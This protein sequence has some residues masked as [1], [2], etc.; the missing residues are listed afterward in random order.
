LR[1]N[2]DRAAGL[3]VAN[4]P[5][6]PR[7][8]TLAKRTKAVNLQAG[9]SPLMDA[10]EFVWV[11]GCVS[12]VFFSYL[13][14]SGIMINAVLIVL[15]ALPL[16]KRF[17]YE[18]FGAL[19]TPFDIPVVLV[20]G[21]AIVGVLFSSTRD[22]SAGA[23]QSLLALMM[24]YYYF[25]THPNPRRIALWVTLLFGILLLGVTIV[26]FAAEPSYVA[27]LFHM[28]PALA[29]LL[30]RVP[31]VPTPGSMVS[32]FT[33]NHG[34]ATSLLIAASLAVCYAL[35]GRHRGMRILSGMCAVAFLA[36][37]AG[38]THAALSRL[39]ELISIDTRM[40]LWTKT[41][42]MLKAHP[43][44]GL[45]L[46]S[47]A[48][49]YYGG[50]V[51]PDAVGHPHSAYLEIY[52]DFGLLGV[53]GFFAIAVVTARMAWRMLRSSRLNPWFGYSV[54]LIVA[55]VLVA[56]VG[57]LESAPI[58]IPLVGYDQYRYVLSPVPWLL[59]GFLAMAYKITALP[60][61]EG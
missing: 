30:E 48:P 52:A 25:A 40:E 5:A 9:T 15:C 32:F 31:T 2:E 13:L 37:L 51:P 29:G 61:R 59:L 11:F 60:R 17:A 16:V 56:I 55:T 7:H 45:G 34:L 44:T 23:F 20:L 33:P 43:F 49:L 53:V 26:S 6:A 19:K 18:G 28:G 1:P 35:S 58:G 24:F 36:L 3:A 38:L 50:A 22:L 42:E 47:W 14:G 41:L 8:T 39:L 46:G 54:G 12:L 27:G 10:L 4:E 21:G 57:F